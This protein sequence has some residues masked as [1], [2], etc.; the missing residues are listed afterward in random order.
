MDFVLSANGLRHRRGSRLPRP[1]YLVLRP[2]V[3][4]SNVLTERERKSGFPKTLAITHGSSFTGDCAR[5]L[6]DLDVALRE[7]FGPQK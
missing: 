5:A 1:P 3:N 2:H 6:H 4:A 7:L